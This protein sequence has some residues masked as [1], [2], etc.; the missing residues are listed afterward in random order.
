LISSASAEALADFFLCPFEAIKIRI[1]TSTNYPSTLCSAARLIY[2][3]E[4]LLGFYKGLPPLWMRQIPYT[5]M[6][7]CSFERVNEFIYYY[8]VPKP[9][10]DCTKA[11]QLMVTLV[12]GYIAGILCAIVSHPADTVV[13]K[14]NKNANATI[15]GVLKEL[16]PIG[17]FVLR[18]LF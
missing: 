6:K 3:T 14:L 4:G 7:F 16:G 1:Q 13:S 18:Y 5:C 9:H 10:S 11:E 17:E 2:D 8:V 12:A 15:L